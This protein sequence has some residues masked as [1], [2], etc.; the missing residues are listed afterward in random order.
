MQTCRA[1]YDYDKQTEEELSFKEGETFNVYDLGDPDWLLVGDSADL[2]F[3]FIPANYIELNAAGTSQITPAASAAPIATPVSNFAPPPQHISRAA[4]PQAEVESEEDVDEVYEDAPPP[5]PSR[6][7]EPEQEEEVAPPKPS[8]PVQAQPTGDYEQEEAVEKQEHSFDGEYF[9]WYIDEVEGRKK[10][11]VILLVGNGLIILKPNTNNPKKLRMR[12]ASS[13]DNN[14]RI[15][16]MVEYNHE[17][18]HVFLEFK[19]PQASIELHAGSKDVAEAIVAVLGDLKGAEQAKGL[20]E[21]AR[22]SLTKTSA[23]NRR[24]GV[25][26]YDFKAQGHDELSVK[27]GD[28]VYVIDLSKSEEWWMCERTSDK[29]Q[30]VVPSS[31]IEIIGTT[32]LDKLTDGV[33]R[34]KSERVGS[35]K[36]RVVDL[37]KKKHHRYTRDERDKIRE[38]DRAKRDRSDRNATAHDDKNMPNYHRVRTWIDSSGSFKV[39]AEFLG[40]VEGKIHLHK[41]NGVKIAVAATKLSIEDLEY[42][43]KVTGTSLKHYKEEVANNTKKRVSGAKTSSESPQKPP[44]APEKDVPTRPR[45]ATATIND[46]PPP[47]PSREKS[48]ALTA[49][50]PDYDWFEFFLQCGVDIGNCQRY[51]I[52]FS[53]EQ[54]DE[55]ILEDISPSLLRSLGL[56]E[57]DILR[58]MKHLDAKFDRKKAAQADAPAGGLFTEPTGALKNNSTT[59]ISKVTASA[60]PVPSPQKEVTNPIG[61]A[62]ASDSKFEDDA[63]AVKPAARSSED[64]TRTNSRPQYTGSLQDLVDIKPLEANKPPQTPQKD[65]HLQPVA[66]SVPSAPAMTPVKTETLIQPSQQFSVQKTGSS[67]QP[68]TASQTGGLV[69]VRTGGLVPVPTGGLIPV[70]TGG[71]IPMQPTGFIPIAAQPTGFV[72]IQQTGGLAPQLTFGIVPLQTGT[73]TFAP[74]K[75]GPQ[76]G[77]PPTTFGQIAMQPTNLFV[78]LQPTNA[79]VPLQQGSVTMPQTSFNQ[80]PTGQFGQPQVTGQFGQPQVTGQFGQTQVTGQ[81]GQPQVTS[82]VTGGLNTFVPQ[83]AFGKQITGGFMPTTSFGAQATGGNSGIMPPT[84]FS[85]QATGGNMPPTLFGAQATGGNMPATSFGQATGGFSTQ[86]VNQVTDMFQNTSIGQPQYQNFGQPNGQ[87]GQANGQFGQNNGQQFG[88]GNGQQFGQFGQFGQ[89]TQQTGF[90][91]QT[92]FN[93]QTG[94]GQANGFGQQTTGYGQPNFGQPQTSF[95]QQ[96]PQFEGFGSQPLQAQPTGLGFGNAPQLQ[97]QQTGRKANLQAATAE[98][99]FGF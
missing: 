10:R 38:S 98:N 30:G 81:F 63:W 76:A 99:P 22:A 44:A 50:E 57:G 90:G 66:P 42:V 9:R 61:S 17:K 77:P 27:E 51:S 52:N 68:L 5:M 35:S 84:S 6:P 97:A 88:Q 73:L 75:T 55:T 46:V 43:E 41:T 60:L 82:Q 13:L 34:R 32:N 93:Q 14:W 80:A 74:Q 3:G 18:K 56:R 58:V 40:C 85:A 33:Q 95:G 72:P 20:K 53:K 25:L 24:V 59:E 15:R 7:A 31:Y 96:Q 54:M 12:S 65:P 21:V 1:L 86:G 92:G 26:L 69:P 64:L 29:K 47:K 67:S 48:S 4:Q 11:A 39:E 23:N 62:T 89:N 91:Q 70:Q 78:P 28:E 94:Y 19:N 87:Y 79:F 36:G 49:N 37:G 8:R 83:S 2:A 45:L 71:L 16:D